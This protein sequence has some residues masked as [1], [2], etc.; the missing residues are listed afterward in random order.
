M[1]RPDGHPVHQSVYRRPVAPRSGD[2]DS[3]RCE[4]A[5]MCSQE[6][7]LPQTCVELLRIT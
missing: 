7:M 5:D 6:W 4:L 3:N 2:R 1:A